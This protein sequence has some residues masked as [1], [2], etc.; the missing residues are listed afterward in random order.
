MRNS[1]STWSAS[2]PHA[3]T[4]RFAIGMMATRSPTQ[5]ISTFRSPIS[6]P[7]PYQG[8]RCGSRERADGR[9][10][11]WGCRQQ[12]GGSQS[13]WVRRHGPHPSI[14]GTPGHSTR[15]FCTISSWSSG[16]RVMKF[17]RRTHHTTV[18]API[19]FHRHIT[20]IVGGDIAKGMIIR[21][22]FLG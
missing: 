13:S 11:C 5:R 4:S 17:D 14:I 8:G 22:N 19:K 16:I 12:K 7:R 1:C 18:G 9:C 10:T 6:S 3:G 21:S 15:R 20:N 2:A